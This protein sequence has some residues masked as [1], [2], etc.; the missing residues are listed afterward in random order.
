M[1]HRA[2][3]SDAKFDFSQGRLSAVFRCRG[4][5]GLEAETEPLSQ[6]LG[7]NIAWEHIAGIRDDG[8]C[9]T[10]PQSSTQGKLLVY[11]VGWAISLSY[12]LTVFGAGH[13]RDW[14]A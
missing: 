6:L 13:G 1:G 12:S 3:S 8:G 5:G 9:A 4:A 10:N 11:R 2:K 7:G 14:I